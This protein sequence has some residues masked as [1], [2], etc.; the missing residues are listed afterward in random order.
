MFKLVKNLFKQSSIYAL[1]DLLT[2]GA[3]FFLLP[4]YTAYLTPE[5]YGIISL[6]TVTAT[7]FG[8]VSTGGLKGAILKFYY[9]FDEEKKRK[10]F[11]GSI[12]LF[13]LLVPGVLLFLFELKGEMIF[14]QILPSVSYHP[15]LR[16]ALWTIYVKTL[17]TE[18]PLQILKAKS[19]AT[20]YSLLKVG[21]FSLSTIF[22]IWF[23]VFLQQGAKGLLFAKYLGNLMIATASVYYLYR[24]IR[25]RFVWGYLKK[26]LLYSLPMVPHYLSHWVLSSSDRFVLEYFVPLGDVGVY[27]VGYTI[28]S[29]MSMIAIA[30]NNAIIPLY[31]DLDLENK[32]GIQDVIKT[33]TYYIATV[34]GIGLLIALFAEDFIF[35]A[36]PKSYH[37]AIDV[38]PWVVLGYVFM[39]FYFT[40]INLLTITLGKTSVVG[41]STAIAALV[42]LGLNIL[43][44]PYLGMEG[45]AITTAFTYFILFLG[46]K[47]FSRREYALDFEYMRMLKVLL[48]G[49]VVFILSYF[50]VPSTPYISIFLK[51]IGVAVFLGLLYISGFFSKE[52][53]EFLRKKIN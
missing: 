20:K 8:I 25:I 2:K 35:L 42:N 10:Q 32:S 5:D 47:Y 12:W 14:Q 36:I 53:V 43:L 52:E 40:Q 6:A 31:G 46:M 24:F 23:V 50:V 48:V 29:A 3:G 15:Y 45:A 22:T 44:I 34:T 17:F 1:G 39:A 51:I 9:D 26:A 11:Y 28:G 7:I 13:Y 21:I 27:N 19:E 37:G 30:G 4:L 18:P 49:I 41:I 16:L 33:A 38:I